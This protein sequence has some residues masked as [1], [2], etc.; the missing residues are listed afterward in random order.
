VP[1]SSAGRRN[2]NRRHDNVVVVALLGIP[3]TIPGQV[4][5]TCGL[6]PCLQVPLL[7]LDNS[8]TI[9]LLR[10][11]PTWLRQ[12]CLPCSWPA[13]TPPVPLSALPATPATSPAPQPWPP[14][15]GS[16]DQRALAITFSTMTLQPPATVTDWIPDQP[17]HSS[18]W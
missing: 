15:A 16:W 18:C 10:R 17:Y 2:K 11:S 9:L 4:Q 7:A 14:W 5:S 6:D 12:D 13:R 8:S 3:S 1:G